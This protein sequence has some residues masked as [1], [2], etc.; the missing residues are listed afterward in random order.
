M[1]VALQK[2]QLAVSFV[3]HFKKKHQ[4]RIRVKFQSY[5]PKFMFCVC[6]TGPCKVCSTKEAI[7]IDSFVGQFQLTL[8]NTRCF[9]FQFHVAKLS[10]YKC[11]IQGLYYT[12][13]CTI[14]E[15]DGFFGRA[16]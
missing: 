11:I 2:K 1:Q 12:G 13:L 15:I 3:E 8:E 4:N 6:S 14:D 5:N 9:E 7:D 16:P 10:Q